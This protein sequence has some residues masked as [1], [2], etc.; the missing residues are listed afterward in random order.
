MGVLCERSSAE[1]DIFLHSIELYIEPDREGMEI[2]R[3][4]HGEGVLIGEVKILFR[5]SIEVSFP[6]SDDIGAYLR[7]LNT[8][9]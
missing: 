2:I 5:D 3:S 9:N 8:I 4:Y 6:E 7:H 1:S